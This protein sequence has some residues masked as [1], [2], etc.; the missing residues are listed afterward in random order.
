MRHR[1][2]FHIAV[3]IVVAAVEAQRVQAE[4]TAQFRAVDP[5]PVVVVAAFG[6]ESAGG[7]EVGVVNG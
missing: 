1:I 7:K 5:R 2:I 6:V 3:Q 4:E